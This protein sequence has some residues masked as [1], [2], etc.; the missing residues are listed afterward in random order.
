KFSAYSQV[1][2]QGTSIFPFK[3]FFRSTRITPGTASPF[4][5]EILSPLPQPSVCAA[6]QEVEGST[7]VLK[8]RLLPGDRLVLQGAIPCF[9]EGAAGRSLK[10]GRAHV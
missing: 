6:A 2:S 1:I 3:G 9:I 7:P 4:G 5:P 8:V 10:I